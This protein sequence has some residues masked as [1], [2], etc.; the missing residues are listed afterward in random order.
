M[1]ANNRSMV[2]RSSCV[3][4]S[5]RTMSGSSSQNASQTPSPRLGRSAAL[6]PCTTDCSGGP[7]P[8]S[9]RPFKDQAPTTSNSDAARDSVHFAVTALPQNHWYRDGPPS[10]VAV[11]CNRSSSR[12]TLCGNSLQNWSPGSGTAIPLT[13]TRTWRTASISARQPAH[14][15]RWVVMSRIRDGSRSN[16]RYGTVNSLISLQVMF[17]PHPYQDAAELVHRMMVIGLRGPFGTAHD[18]PDVRKGVVV[19]DAQH[20]GFPLPRRQGPDRLPQTVLQLG[21]GDLR[22]GIVRGRKRQPFHIL[23]MRQAGTIAQRV[24]ALVEADL[25]DPGPKAGLALEGPMMEED[26]HERLLRHVG[27]V[28]MVLQ[29]SVRQVVDGLLMARDQLLEG[30]VVAGRVAVQELVVRRRHP[31]RGHLLYS[32]RHAI[33]AKVTRENQEKCGT[34]VGDPIPLVHWVVSLIVFR[35]AIRL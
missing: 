12:R 27:R 25:I 3:A 34:T 9:S 32:L 11:L 31:A 21:S 33:S 13:R 22:K 14:P 6:G 5:T 24:T 10:V 2:W 1:S 30:R 8:L 35:V 17:S 26:L 16:S 15:S 4:I 20:Q 28:S 18:H 7:V 23:M 19:I 29:H